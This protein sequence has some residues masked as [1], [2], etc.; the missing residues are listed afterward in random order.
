MTDVSG[1]DEFNNHGWLLSP[2]GRVST[3]PNGLSMAYKW[4]V[5][6]TSWDDPPSRPWGLFE[7][8]SPVP[9]KCIYFL[10]KMGM[11]H[12]YASLSEDIWDYTTLSYARW[13][14]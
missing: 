7:A 13:G 2:K 11:F 1:F 14:P 12:C 6:I 3:L 5:P 9:L 10:W 8:W 4:W